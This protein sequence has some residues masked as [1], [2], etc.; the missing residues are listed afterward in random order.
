[1]TQRRDRAGQLFE[2]AVICQI[3][4]TA[5]ALGLGWRFG[6]LRTAG[7]DHEVDLISDLPDGSV[8]AFEAKLSRTVSIADARHLQVL[9]EQ[10]GTSLRAGLIVHPGENSYRLAD[11]IAAVARAALV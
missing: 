2:S 7:G 10:L 11:G 3:R 8:L 4:A 9:K 1:M 6:H 5:D